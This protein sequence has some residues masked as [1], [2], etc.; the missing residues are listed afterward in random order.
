M[1]S[2]KHIA[3]VGSVIVALFCVGL[4]SPSPAAAMINPT[5]YLGW[6]ESAAEALTIEVTEV[7]API[8]QARGRDLLPVT[9]DATAKVMAVTRS[10]SGLKPGDV[11]RIRYDTEVR[12]S[13]DV[14][15]TCFAPVPILKN[16]S[17]VPAFLK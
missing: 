11:L 4:L 6:Q 3:R 17:T 14:I 1:A 7:T 16:G 15:I 5:Y 8:P 12:A 10:A 13:D 2:M 9:V